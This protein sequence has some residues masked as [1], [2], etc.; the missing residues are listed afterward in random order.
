MGKY[1]KWLTS[2]DPPLEV[3]E[4]T[5]MAY[6]VNLHTSGYAPTT[7][8][9]VVSMLKKQSISKSLG[10]KKT[11]WIKLKWWL[12][13]VSKNYTPKQSEPFTLKEIVSFIDS[14]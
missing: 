6:A 14:L 8:R 4:N 1:G 2:Q 11:V 3:D 5:V 13:Q 10:L 9:S 7:I 12:D